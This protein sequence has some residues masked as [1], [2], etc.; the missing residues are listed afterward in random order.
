MVITHVKMFSIF[1]IA[2]ISK[3]LSD[4]MKKGQF[5]FMY[6]MIKVILL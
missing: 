1:L 5:G 4:T 3:L 2:V 6:P